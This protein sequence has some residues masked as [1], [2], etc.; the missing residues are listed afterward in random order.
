VAA[1][2][3]AAAG[4]APAVNALPTP[5]EALPVAVAA[6][7]VVLGVGLACVRTAAAGARL[8]AWLVAA[9]IAAAALLL[10]STRWRE[11]ARRTADVA[12]A[13]EPAAVRTALLAAAAV[14]DADAAAL[15]AIWQHP[16]PFAAGALGVA[17]AMPR[18]LPFA[19]EQLQVSVVGEAARDRPLALEL[20][21]LP[22]DAPLPGELI[23]RVGGREVLRADVAVGPAP[24]TR[25]FVP[26]QDGV[27]TVELAVRAGEH[28]I[29]A[30]GA[31]EVAAAPRVLVLEPRPLLT[32]ALRAQGVAAERGDALPADL[33]GHAAVVVASPLTASAQQT[34]ADAVTAGAGAFVTGAAFGSEREPM[35]TLLPLRPFPQQPE[36]SAANDAPGPGDGPQPPPRDDPPPADVPPP[37]P[38]PPDDEPQPPPSGRTGEPGK[39]SAEPIDVDKRAIAMVLVVDRSKSM[40]SGLGERHSKMSYAKTSALRTAEALAEGDMIGIVTF[41]VP[42]QPRIVLPM[43]DATAQAQIRERIEELAATDNRTFLKDALVQATRMLAGVDAAVKHVVVISDGEWEDGL[44]V[45]EPV[46]SAREDGKVTVSIICMTDSYTAASFRITARSLATM[47][48]GAWLPT[49]DPREVPAFVSAEVTRSLQ[50]VGRTPRTGA[51]PPVAPQPEPPQPEPPQPQPPQPEPPQP[52][53]APKRPEERPPARVPVRA[54]VDSALLAPPPA[55]WPSLARAIAGDAPFDAHVLLVAG[56]AGWPLLAFGNRGLGRVG[57]FAADLGGDPAA[58]FRAEP[59]FAARLAQ[60]VQSVLPPRAVAAPVPLLTA[61]AVEPPAP[62]P[63]DVLAMTALATGA[64]LDTLPEPAAR[65]ERFTLPRVPALAGALVAALVLLALVE[66][67]AAARALHTGAVARPR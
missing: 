51:E 40:A 59:A 14:V 43:T 42:T 35:R 32:D 61:H 45:N 17:V 53:E 64:P 27:H 20:A 5:P 25:T 46:R 3:A 10:P 33:R 49:D 44:A 4:G 34:L 15:R 31:V 18:A 29:R 23:V 62:A 21:A 2:D 39:P 48:G 6:A 16:R 26:A 47:G 37:P 19:P 56:D 54:V 50:R 7:M 41:G 12:L 13:G 67:L 38:P 36:P 57:A 55:S 28:T 24:V 60:W 22:L 65:V 52:V 63:A 9:A 11:V 8:C 1:A 30:T 66:R 58:E